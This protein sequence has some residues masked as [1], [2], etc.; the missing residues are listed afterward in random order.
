MR[1]FITAALAT[2][3]ACPAQSETAADPKTDLAT[4]QARAGTDPERALLLSSVRDNLRSLS[5]QG[6]EKDVM[7]RY[8]GRAR[9]LLQNGQSFAYQI[10]GQ[11]QAAQERAQMMGQILQAD[12]NGDWQVS[13]EELVAVLRVDRGGNLSDVFIMGDMNGDDL[14]SQEEMQK[15]VSDAAGLRTDRYQQDK[16]AV[17]LFDLNDDGIL[18]LDEVNRS[19]AAMLL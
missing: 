11:R 15:T 1:F 14:L 19:V 12:L 18:T 6:S 5:A 7:M 13:R 8:L 10:E 17:G 2:L 9:N 4:L 3:L 16:D